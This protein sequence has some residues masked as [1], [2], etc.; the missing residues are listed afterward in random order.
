MTP[1]IR[2]ALEDLKLDRIAVVYPDE[3]RFMLAPKIE[4]VPLV[5]VPDGTLFD[6][7]MMTFVSLIF[8]CQ[9]CAFDRRRA[10]GRYA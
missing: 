5:T 7:G 8:Y 9:F 4:A 10:E 2:I 3:K 6:G 1:S